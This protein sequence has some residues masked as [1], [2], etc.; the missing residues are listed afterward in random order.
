[1]A[2]M[3]DLIFGKNSD[4]AVKDAQEFQKKRDAKRKAK[5]AAKRKKKSRTISGREK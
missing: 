2:I 1:M 4:K 5:K 3:K